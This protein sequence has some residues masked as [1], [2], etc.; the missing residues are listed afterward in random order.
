MCGIHSVS[1]DVFA[2]E[3]RFQ[4]LMMELTQRNCEFVEKKRDAAKEQ[5]EKQILTFIHSHCFEVDFSLSRLCELADYSPTFINR[6]LMDETGLSYHHYISSL[7]LEKA[8]QELSSTQDK[9]KDIVLRC[10]YIDIASFTRKFKEYEG[11]TPGEYRMQHQKYPE[12][13]DER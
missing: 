1:L 12:A 8:K 3:Q 2:N 7:R 9:I 11:L 10:G 13:E 5:R 4:A 6:F